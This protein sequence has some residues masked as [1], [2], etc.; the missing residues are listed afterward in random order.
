MITSQPHLRKKLLRNETGK[1]SG[2]QIAANFGMLPSDNSIK[3]LQITGNLG[4]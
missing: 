1:L 2:P 3:K 4:T